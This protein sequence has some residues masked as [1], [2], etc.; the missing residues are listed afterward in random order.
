MS[1][2]LSIED[3]EAIK[4]IVR[5]VVRD[6][7]QRAERRQELKRKPEQPKPTSP[8]EVKRAERPQEI[9]AHIRRT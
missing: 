3:L 2:N 8:A 9:V 1:S 5:E 7:L 4:A 6:E